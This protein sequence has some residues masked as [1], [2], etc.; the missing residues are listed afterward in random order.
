MVTGGE[1]VDVEA[2]LLAEELQGGEVKLR[3]LVLLV[4]LTVGKEN[5]QS[6]N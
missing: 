1:H 3:A 5:E 2:I 4:S 6:H